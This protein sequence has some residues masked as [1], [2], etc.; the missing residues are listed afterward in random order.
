MKKDIKLWAHPGWLTKNSS[1]IYSG[2]T[3]SRS[4]M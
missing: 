1:K 4:N 3:D 2:A